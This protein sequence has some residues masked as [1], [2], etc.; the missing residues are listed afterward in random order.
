MGIHPGDIIMAKFTTYTSK[1]LPGA[2]LKFTAAGISLQT[3]AHK[4]CVSVLSHVGRNHDVRMVSDLL[5]AMPD[6]ARRNAVKDWFVAFGPV[7][8][9][10]DTISYVADKATEIAKGT[11][12]PFWKFSPEPLYVAIDVAKMLQKSVKRLEKD[13]TETGRDHSKTIKALQNAELALQ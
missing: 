7:A 13:A 12:E 6:M 1:Q 4:L 11:A 2:M 8:I 3:E 9:D 10:G 5:K